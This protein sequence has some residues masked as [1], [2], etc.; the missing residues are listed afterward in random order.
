MVPQPRFSSEC[1]GS[2]R[3]LLLA[4]SN[5][6]GA[7]MGHHRHPELDLGSPGTAVGQVRRGSLLPGHLNLERQLQ[8]ADVEF[9][10][11]EAG[12]RSFQERR[13]RTYEALLE[14]GLGDIQ[15][16][17]RIVQ[18]QAPLDEPAKRY[19]QTAIFDRTWGPRIREWLSDAEWE[20]RSA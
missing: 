3:E 10:K 2:I 13:Q 15:V 17:T 7:I 4:H 20:L 18:R 16:E 5:Q 11:Q 12:E 6:S 1:V 19:I 9:Q 14:T 8:R